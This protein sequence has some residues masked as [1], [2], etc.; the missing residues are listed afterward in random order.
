MSTP[1]NPSPVVTSA[2]AEPGSAPRRAIA[3]AWHTVLLILVLIAVSLSGAGG[4]QATAVAH[5]GRMPLYLTT[6]GFEWLVVLYVIWGVR[7]RGVTLRELTGGRWAAPEDA[8]LDVAIALGFLVVFWAAVL[9]V[10]SLAMKALGI[11]PPTPGNLTQTCAELKR[12]VGFLA[13]EGSREIAVWLLA[14]VTAGFCEEIIYRGYLQRQF[15]ALTRVMALGVILQAIMFGASHGY[16]G[17]PRMLL[18]F[19]YGVAFG[20]LAIWRRSL[21]PGMIAHT[22]HDGFGGLMIRPLLGVI[23][24]K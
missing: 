18:I 19:V 20:F 13:P 17:A 16:E 12:R 7:K 2:V 9:V 11:S 14:S 10:L 23:G 3:P 5:H 15:A 6:I 8:L 22:I 21:R 1:E 24:C 4:G